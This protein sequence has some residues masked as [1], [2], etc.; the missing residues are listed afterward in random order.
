MPE[1]LEG[2]VSL[3]AGEGRHRLYLGA[4]NGQPTDIDMISGRFLLTITHKGWAS[5]CVWAD[6]IQRGDR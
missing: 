4:I 1:K 6:K 2:I 5:A 3:W